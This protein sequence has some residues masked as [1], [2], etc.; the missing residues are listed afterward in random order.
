MQLEQVVADP[1]LRSRLLDA[2]VHA[3]QAEVQS[4]SGVTG[5]FIKK[6][7]GAFEAIRPGMARH[8]FEQLLPSFV[9]AL[10]PHW[11]AARGTDVSDYFE[12]HREDVATA[13]LAVTD[14]RAA[15]AKNAVLATL[16]RSLRGRAQPH[17][18]SAVPRIGD[19]L[20]SVLSDRSLV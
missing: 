16:Y 13:L 18:A 10:S 3:V 11:D 1:T 9:P 20:A 4:K 19:I 14:A 15:K 7:Y 6:G 8:M 5:L 12:T 2:C 17:V